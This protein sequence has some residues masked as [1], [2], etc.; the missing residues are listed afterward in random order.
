ME[1]W[2]AVAR[3]AVLAMAIEPFYKR[4]GITWRGRDVSEHKKMPDFVAAAVATYPGIDGAAEAIANGSLAYPFAERAVHESSEFH[5]GSRSLNLGLVEAILPAI[6]GEILYNSPLGGAK[7]FLRNNTGEGDVHALN[8]MLG[9][10]WAESRKPSQRAVAKINISA[11]NAWEYYRSLKGILEE[12]ELQGDVVYVSEILG[13]W[14]IA[15]EFYDVL[16]E[17]EDAVYKVHSRVMDA[18][19]LQG[20]PGVPADFLAVAIFA[21]IVDGWV[22]SFSI[23]G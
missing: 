11:K 10:T 1:K 18:Y 14:S 6:G 21:K 17:G 19:Q 4:E 20:S 3:A 7:Q 13:S 9:R 2:R 8:R 16:G 23:Y 5:G 15:K 22:P 12:Y